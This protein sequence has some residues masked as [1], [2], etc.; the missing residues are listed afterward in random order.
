MVWNIQ[1]NFTTLYKQTFYR[2]FSRF[3]LI[4]F[5]GL[6]N[7]PKHFKI[8]L[9]KVFLAFR[10]YSE[11]FID[12]L[13]VYGLKTIKSAKEDFFKIKQNSQS[14]FKPSRKLFKVDIKAFHDI[15]L[16][17]NPRL[18]NKPLA[19]FKPTKRDLNSSKS[20]SRS[21]KGHKTFEPFHTS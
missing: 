16:N 12:H 13:K 9:S 18:L 2:P 14:F 1:F 15:S 10:K 7:A 5:P 8:L 19:I 21:S 4:N 6:E 11:A 20:L 3:I 17:M